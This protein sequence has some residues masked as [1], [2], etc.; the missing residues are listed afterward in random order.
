NRPK[1]T[2]SLGLSAGVG[3]T[4]C[5]IPGDGPESPRIDLDE[6]GAETLS[7]VS[8]RVGMV[9]DDLASGL[10]RLS[11]SRQVE[12][13]RDGAVPG[14]LDLGMQKQPALGEL[15]DPPIHELALALRL[16]GGAAIDPSSTSS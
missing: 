4:D 13:H 8:D 10:D 12:A 2:R 5:D 11:I 16:S 14:Q 1:A 9:V 3:T 6:L 15:S 7:P